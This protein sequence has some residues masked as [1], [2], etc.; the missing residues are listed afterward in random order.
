[1]KAHLSLNV[2]NVGESIEFYKKMFGADPVKVK[3]DYA[4]FDLASPQLNFT[5]NQVSVTA[6]GSLSHL[7]VQVETSD[8]VRA[9]GRRWKEL[10]LSTLEE[11]KTDCCY[12][13]QDKIWVQDPDG[14]RWEVFNVIGDTDG[15]EAISCCAKS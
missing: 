14:N 2:R 12:A 1:M 10:G 3:A 15:A 9:I 8:E 4:K 7:G 6:G 13:R 5:M 11:M